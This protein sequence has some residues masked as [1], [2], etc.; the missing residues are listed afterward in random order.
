MSHVSERIFQVSLDESIWRKFLNL[1]H[2]GVIDF[3]FETRQTR[4]SP[5]LIRDFK[6]TPETLPRTLEQWFELYHPD[7][8]AKS[9]EFRRLLFESEEEAFS[10]ERR[11]Y[12]GDGRYRRFRIDAVCFRDSEGQNKIRRLLGV[13]TLL[14]EESEDM[15]GRGEEPPARLQKA[16]A[17]GMANVVPDLL[18]FC[19][20]G[21]GLTF[22]NEAFSKALVRNP[23][24]AEWAVRVANKGNPQNIRQEAR[25]SYED[26]HGRLRSLRTLF[27]PFSQDETKG[28]IGVASDVTELEEMEADMA[29]LKRLLGKSALFE[30]PDLEKKPEKTDPALSP[31]DKKNDKNDKNDE[32]DF[33]EILGQRLKNVLSA[34]SDS[35]IEK[36]FPARRAQIETL[37]HAAEKAELEVG[38]IGITSS[39]KSTFINSMMGERLLPE[40]T[41]ATTNLVLR[42]RKGKE[43]G[44]T[45]VWKNG[46]RERVLGSRLTAGWMES[47]TSERLNPANERTVAFLEWTSPA[48]VVPEGLT[49]VDTP[50]LDACDFPE[51]SGMLL[52]QLLPTLDIVIYVTSIRNRLKAADLESL[53]AVLG[54]DQRVIFLLSQIDLERDDT[55]G[56]KVVFSRDQKLSAYVRELRQDLEKGFPGERSLVKSAIVPVS[57]KLAMRYF[58][59]RESAGWRTSNFGLVIGQLETFRANLRRHKSEACARRAFM[60]FSRTAFDVEDRKST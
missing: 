59:D 57:S 2:E 46:E 5:Q 60:L 38:V 47:L 55:E 50:G 52:R 13:E 51:Y 15:D 54:Q 11:L 39:G 41:Q 9:L 33:G 16:L 36:L 45:V 18:F 29:R 31:F 30:T 7:D 23:D 35:R 44:V 40:E 22:F 17:V 28:V 25:R 19:E 26:S 48:A 58:Y 42:C 49:L 3:D 56:G 6:L 1:T 24:L 37:I 21:D 32:P 53:E 43:R 8:Y 12:C 10:L 4:C 20:M 14:S 27:F 34:L